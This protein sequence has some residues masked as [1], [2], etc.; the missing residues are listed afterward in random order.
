MARALIYKGPEIKY[1]T[2]E[3]FIR[4][5]FRRDEDYDYDAIADIIFGRLD[6]SIAGLDKRLDWRAGEGALY[7]EDDGSGRPLPKF[8]LAWWQAQ[9]N[10]AMLGL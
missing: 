6:A 5:W 8:D 4:D 10:A 2:L 1:N 9:L 7:A 3:Y